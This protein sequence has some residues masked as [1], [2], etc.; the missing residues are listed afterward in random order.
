MFFFYLSGTRSHTLA[1]YATRLLIIKGDFQKLSLAVYGN[2]VSEPGPAP[3]YEAKPLS[4][5]EPVPLT[6]AVDP[7]NSSDPL[8]LARRLLLLIPGSPS[9]SLVI[10]LMLCLKPS[11][12]DWDHP[13]FPYLH[14]YIDRDEAAFDLESV[15][16]NLSRPLPEDTTIETL[17][18]F[19]SRVADLIGPKVIESM[20]IYRTF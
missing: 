8:D 15:V 20:S 1:Q 6:K 17:E 14:A 7:A 16:Q 11:N 4:A 5:P 2:I 9:L 19:A 3:A 18:A 10:R 13:D 12:D